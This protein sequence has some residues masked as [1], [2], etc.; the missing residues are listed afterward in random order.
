M[1]TKSKEQ[2]HTTGSIPMTKKHEKTIKDMYK[3]MK[4]EHRLRHRISLLHDRPMKPGHRMVVDLAS[5]LLKQEEIHGNGFWRDIKSIVHGVSKIPFAS[6]ILGMI[7]PGI[8]VAFEGAK[9]LA[10]DEEQ[11][12]NY[13]AAVSRSNRDRQR[14]ASFNTRKTREDDDDR[15]RQI[16]R[17]NKLRQ[18][19]MNLKEDE[20]YKKRVNRKQAFKEA[21]ETIKDRYLKPEFAHLAGTKG[22]EHAQVRPTI[23][24]TRGGDIDTDKKW[25]AYK[26]SYMK[27]M[28][29]EPDVVLKNQWYKL[30]GQ[31]AKKEVAEAVKNYPPPSDVRYILPS[32]KYI[33]EYEMTFME[34]LMNN[35]DNA[36]AYREAK[37]AYLPEK[38]E[39]FQEIYAQRGL[40]F[41]GINPPPETKIVLVKNILDAPESRRPLMW[42]EYR[43]MMNYNSPYETDAERAKYAITPEDEYRK[44]LGLI[45]GVVPES[46]KEKK[47]RLDKEAEDAE[48][49]RA[50]KQ[51][52]ETKAS[53][54]QESKT[55]SDRLADLNKVYETPDIAT[56]LDDLVARI[57][58]AT[59]YDAVPPGELEPL[60]RFPIM[61]NYDQNSRPMPLTE[62]LISSGISGQQ[63]STKEFGNTYMN[64]KPYAFLDM[65]I[66][67]GRLGK[68]DYSK[69]A[70]SPF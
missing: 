62:W 54:E 42:R 9:A 49:T 34:K 63:F 67:G 7:H 15:L 68:I 29:R 6:E 53:E 8:A 16:D 46:D 66:N 43:D 69:L 44:L 47:I 56:G 58:Q 39:R 33:P 23:R 20:E 55:E 37:A 10:G 2:K 65:P 1:P 59:E 31:T 41:P 61:Y 18:K 30:Q 25:E 48:L 40:V 36:D 57:S 11:A 5:H 24:L 50:A 28:G 38:E 12:F 70:Y 51:Q 27:R 32:V 52:A 60:L 17:R 26:T 3:G 64:Q 22:F 14:L 19:A 21:S 35:T 45:R 13:D 4:P